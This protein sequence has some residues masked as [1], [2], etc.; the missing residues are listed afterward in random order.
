VKIAFETS[1]EGAFYDFDGIPEVTIPVR[2]LATW[3]LAPGQP[4]VLHQPEWDHKVAPQE[5]RFEGDKAVFVHTRNATHDTAIFRKVSVTPGP[6]VVNCMAMLKSHPDAGHGVR[7]GVDPFGGIDYLGEDVV[8]SSWWSTY[9]DEYVHAEW[10][11]LSVNADAQ[12]VEV[13]IFLYS[14][15]D[16]PADLAAAH[17]DNVQVWDTRLS[18]GN[19]E[20]I[21]ALRGLLGTARRM[22]V[23]L[24]EMLA[25]LE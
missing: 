4:G 12:S 14:H 5:E 18:G 1:F 11:P 3:Q 10:V 13:T 15:S 8:W 21:E 9:M 19:E 2:W 20:L 7:I 17:F 24:E 6:I 25:V 16:F 23:K 22:V